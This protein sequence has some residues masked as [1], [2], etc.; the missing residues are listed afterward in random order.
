LKAILLGT[1]GGPAPKR[2]RSAPANAIVVGGDI[3]VVD[4]GNGVARQAALAGLDLRRLR[5]VFLT[6]H[7][8]D[9]N[10][11]AGTLLQLAWTA[12]LDRPVQI[13]GPPPLRAMMDAFLRYADV[14]VRTRIEDEGRPDFKSLLEI[15]EIDGG[16]TIVENDRVTVRAA[17]VEHP[18]LRPSFALRFETPER[19]IVFSGDTAPCE[20]LV[21]LAQGADV[22][23]HEVMHGG[24]IGE[25]IARLSN[26][27]RLR[28]HL[29][30]SHT[31]LDDVGTVASRAGVGTLVL[32]HFVPSEGIADEVWRAGAAR[33][34]PGEIIVG[35]D[36]LEL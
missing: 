30:A 3:Y 14:D 29:M 19:S 11:D 35:S 17:L 26:A 32:T 21:E 22:L 25:I 36:L 10:V 6:H 23:V 28:E 1:A 34:F 7:H 27:S 24:A 18:P 8:S 4:C 2:T 16:G 9:H 31:L 5:A 15:V 33:G 12:G 13:F 20:A